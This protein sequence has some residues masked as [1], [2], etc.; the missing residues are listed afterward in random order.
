MA[1]AIGSVLSSYAGR[2]NNWSADG[3]VPVSESPSWSGQY[4]SLN[5]TS[6]GF[7]ICIKVQMPKFQGIATKVTFTFSGAHNGVSTTGKT[8]ANIHPEFTAYTYSNNSDS[9][10]VDDA[11]PGSSTGEVSFSSSSFAKRTV[12]I[13]L[14][15][16][17]IS[18]KYY[19]IYLHTKNSGVVNRIGA[20]STDYTLTLE[21]TPT[22]M[23]SF[24]ANGGSGSTASQEVIIGDSVKLASNNFAAP[25]SQLYTV[26]LNGNGGENGTPKYD[27]NA[28]FNWRLGS[29]SGTIYSPGDEY[30]P[31]GDTK[32]YAQWC[33]PTTF[34]STSRKEETRPG[35]T[36]TFDAKTNGGECDKVSETAQDDVTFSFNS[37]NS[38]ADGSKSTYNSTTKYKVISNITLYAQWDE[39]VTLGTIQPPSAKKESSREITVTLNYNNGSGTIKKLTSLETSTYSFK[40]W[41]S[42]PTATSGSTGK[43][44]P[45]SSYTIYAI[46]G[47]ASKTYEEITLPELKREGYDFLG[48]GTSINSTENL[49][50]P[51]SY[52]PTSDI[53]FYAIWKANG[54]VRIY[55]EGQ[56]YRMAQVYLFTTSDNKWHLTVPYLYDGSWHISS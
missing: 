45:S 51:G 18:E 25:T 8:Y 24:N 40:G 47:K 15:G 52:T 54:A 35:Y 5:N 55:I 43:W 11:V 21:Y 29:T 6:K 1:I 41:S 37:W 39:T 17:I 4:S 12:E 22:Y 13:T 34:G 27:S 36:L 50:N 38:A 23:V 46:F 9:D 42:D 16:N 48:W 28:F 44:R 26:T 2:E 56:G 49:Q 33:T 31:T 10:Y 19:Y 7:I 14:N 3:W 20:S 53:T 30:E 32:F